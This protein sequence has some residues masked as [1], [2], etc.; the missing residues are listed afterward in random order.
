MQKDDYDE[1]VIEFLNTTLVSF[2]LMQHEGE[3][4]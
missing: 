4:P 1:I 3:Q 2:I